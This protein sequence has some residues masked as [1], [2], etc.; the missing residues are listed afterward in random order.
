MTLTFPKVNICISVRK[1]N[2]SWFLGH[3]VCILVLNYTFKIYVLCTL[4]WVRKR[5]RERE[6]RK[7]KERERDVKMH[8]VMLECMLFNAQEKNRNQFQVVVSKLRFRSQW[9]KV[10]MIQKSYL[11][12][13][14]WNWNTSKIYHK[15]WFLLYLYGSQGLRNFEWDKLLPKIL[16][17]KVLWMIWRQMMDSSL[18]ILYLLWI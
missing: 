18:V 2:I 9:S 6:R 1:I 7:E 10:E 8:Q 3:T 12:I 16:P 14:N 13:K 4:E 11:G 5:E 17:I 15:F